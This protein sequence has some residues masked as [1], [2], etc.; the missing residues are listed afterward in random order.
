MF[1][2]PEKF[3]R[4][5]SFRNS[6]RIDRAGCGQIQLGYALVPE[7]TIL[8]VGRIDRDAKQVGLANDILTTGCD[9]LSKLFNH[10]GREFFGFETMMNGLAAR[11]YEIIQ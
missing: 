6:I 7:P 8:S 1:K 10:Q 9:A 2:E 3:L 5:F 4:L 11:F